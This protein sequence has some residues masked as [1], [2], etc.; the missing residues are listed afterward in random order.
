MLNATVV[1]VFH[2][3]EVVSEHFAVA[4]FTPLVGAIVEASKFHPASST[5]AARPDA[6]SRVAS[7]IKSRCI[8]APDLWLRAQINGGYASKIARG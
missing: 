4:T 7:S 6:M 8:S 2:D 1:V 3:P 5:T